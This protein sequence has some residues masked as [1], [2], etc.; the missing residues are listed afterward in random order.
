VN[1]SGGDDRR[2]LGNSAGAPRFCRLDF[3]PL[4]F[5]NRSGMPLHPAGHARERQLKHVMI[6]GAT[7]LMMLL[8]RSCCSSLRHG[9]AMAECLKSE[10]PIIRRLRSIG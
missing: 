7:L 6:E 9:L 3:S 1:V 4:R 2:L 5:A 8:I 10:I